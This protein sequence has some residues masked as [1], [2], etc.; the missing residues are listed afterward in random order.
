MAEAEFS[1]LRQGKDEMVEKFLARFRKQM[2][3]A[4]HKDGP[5]AAVQ[6]FRACTLSKL[7]IFDPDTHISV[8][9]V[10]DSM[11]KAEVSLIMTGKMTPNKKR[12][13]QPVTSG[14]SES[15]GERKA[16]KRHRSPSTSSSSDD[17]VKKSAKTKKL[18]KVQ[19]I[20]AKGRARQGNQTPSSPEK[21]VQQS[22]T[23]DD[24]STIT[25]L[26]PLS[27]T[28]VQQSPKTCQVCGAAGHEALSCPHNAALIQQANYSVV[29]QFCSK[30][31]HTSL[32]CRSSPCSSCGRQGHVGA[33][34]RSA[35][36]Q[37]LPFN[38][39]QKHY[40]ANAP[41]RPKQCFECG[42]TGHIAKYCRSKQN[43][44]V[45]RFD[46]GQRQRSMPSQIQLFAQS[47]S[48]Q[49]LPQPQPPMPPS[50]SSPMDANNNVAL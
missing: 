33:V 49:Y 17:S 15:E 8:N 39:Q 34:C 3:A 23:I 12:R 6:F 25:P 32:Y 31:G 22:P 42:Q 29:C 10:A 7:V 45:P 18:L 47:R 36:N 14:S 5:S 26:Q 16:K 9:K 19:R 11:K 20:N 50:L 13:L 35:G 4:D 2:R 24:P 30:S 48:Q 37:A 46:Q 27:V 40:N 43:P 21:P 41:Q 44:N 38:Q 1:S 28:M